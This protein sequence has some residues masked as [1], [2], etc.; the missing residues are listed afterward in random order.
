MVDPKILLH[1]INPIELIISLF[2]PCPI[3]DN[4][5]TDQNSW[6]GSVGDL[7]FGIYCIRPRIEKVLEDN[8]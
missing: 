8:K 3:C 6:A 7:G 2:K 4:Y 5:P 1:E